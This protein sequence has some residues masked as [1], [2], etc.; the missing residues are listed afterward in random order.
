MEPEH[1]AVSGFSFEL[2][3]RV[4]QDNYFVA[5]NTAVF[6]HVLYLPYMLLDFAYL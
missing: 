5:S 3:N 1:I 6:M 4:T 2:Y